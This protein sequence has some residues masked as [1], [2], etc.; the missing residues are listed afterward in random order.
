[1]NISPPALAQCAVGRTAKVIAALRAFS[2]L[3]YS[4]EIAVACNATEAFASI[5]TANPRDF[6]WTIPLIEQR[7]C[8]IRALLSR[9]GITNVVELGSG[10]S[11]LGLEISERPEY[12]FVESD[13]PPVLE[14]KSAAVLDIL[15]TRA[16]SRRNIQFLPVNAASRDDFAHI[17]DCFGPGP[18]AVLMDGLLHHL[19]EDEKRAVASNVRRLLRS[20]G[21]VWITTDLSLTECLRDLADIDTNA[22]SVIRAISGH[23]GLAIKRDSFY[24]DE[25]VARFFGGMGFRVAKH[26]QSDLVPRLDSLMAVPVDAGMV[27]VIRRK[28]GIWQLTA[29]RPSK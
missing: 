1:M 7:S 21:G 14:E 26:R 28:C 24:C 6:F 27:D 18:V 22:I 9:S 5:V 8:A 23:T 3:P 2:N 4:G 17:Y 19:T 16:C 15:S 13:L 12:T 11:S 29:D 25:Q 10:F 20:R